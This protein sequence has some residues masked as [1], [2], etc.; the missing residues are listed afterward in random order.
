MQTRSRQMAAGALAVLALAAA[1]WWLAT[2]TGAPEAPPV[3]AAPDAT[4]SAR[5]D[6]LLAEDPAFRD[7]LVFLLVATLRDRCVPSQAGLLAR[8]ANR[9]SLPVLA[10]VSAVTAREAAL[11]RPIYQYIQHR[12]DT[13][14]CDQPLQLPAAGDRALEVDAAQYALT[15]PDSY[16]DPRRTS[17]P[18][19][20]DGQPLAARV[21]NACNTVVYSVLPLGGN[22]WR[23][24]TLRAQARSRVRGLCEDEL[25]RQHGTVGGELDSAIGQGLEP[26]VVQAMAALPPECR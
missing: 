4:A 16:F 11:D 7:D 2:R 22:D 18:R 21:A 13:T 23:C 25:R 19:D 20:F 5:I 24:A 1:A 3:A 6:A 8:M 12:A 9:A 15:F 10:G 26:A 17:I 14:A